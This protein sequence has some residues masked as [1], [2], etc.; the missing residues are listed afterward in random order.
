[1]DWKKYQGKLLHIKVRSVF[2]YAP[3]ENKVSV[4][5]IEADEFVDFIVD[6]KEDQE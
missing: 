3:G 4:D 2:P 5:V 1:M 6:S